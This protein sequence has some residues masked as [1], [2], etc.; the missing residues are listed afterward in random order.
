MT[1]VSRVTGQRTTACR[2]ERLIRNFGSAMQLPGCT[3]ECVFLHFQPPMK[4]WVVQ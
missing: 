3:S 4:L 2:P 1:A